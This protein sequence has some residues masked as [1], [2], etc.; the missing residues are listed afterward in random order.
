MRKTIGVTCDDYKAKKYRKRLLEKG[1]EIVHDEPLLKGV[2]VH[3]FKVEV[4][5]ETGTLSDHTR[6]VEHHDL[7]LGEDGVLAG[8]VLDA[9]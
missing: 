1:F 5:E 3:L 6:A 7:A 9:H 2:N 4:D 8:V